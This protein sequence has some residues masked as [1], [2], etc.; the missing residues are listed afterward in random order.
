M[1]KDFPRSRRIAE[2]IQREIADLI[3]TEVK[4][5]RVSS[6]VTVTDV[7][8]TRDQ[9]HAK[10]FFTILGDPEKIEETTLGLKRSAGFLRSQLAQRLLLRTVPQLD[11]K[12]DASVERGMKLTRL[13]DEAVGS[14]PKPSSDE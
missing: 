6:M 8:V 4:D 11:F 3:R 13:I 10:I 7:E 12:Y 9:A 14:T 5:P 2:Q 1:P